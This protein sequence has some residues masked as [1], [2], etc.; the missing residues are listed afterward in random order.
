M[1]KLASIQ[2]ILF[3]LQNAYNPALCIICQKNKIRATM[4]IQLGK[5]EQLSFHNKSIFSKIIGNAC[6]SSHF[7]MFMLIITPFHI[8]NIKM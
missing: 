8:L 1:E 5:N 4:T 3:S 6:I 2:L 7:T